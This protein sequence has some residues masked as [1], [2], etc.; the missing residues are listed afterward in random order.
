MPS[1]NSI[2]MSQ[3]IKI[4]YCLAGTF[5]S[6]GME[7]VVTD[8]ANWLAANGYD[9]TIVTT[10]QK[11]RGDF[12]PLDSSIR[13]IDLEILYSETNGFNPLKKYFAREKR[14]KLH[15][16]KLQSVVDSI[17]P[18]IIVS[19]FG[20][21][22]GIVPKIKTRAKK[23]A[24]IHFSKWY[25]MQL[26]RPG[27]WKWFDR[28]L[29][30]QDQSLLGYYNRFVALTEEDSKNW[31]RLG[32]MVVIP[33]FVKHIQPCGADLKNKKMVAV[34][35]LSYQKGY[36][37]MVKAWK[38]VTQKHPDWRME[39]FGSGELKEPIE[40]LIIAE[41]LQ[42]KVT[43]HRPVNDLDE[44]YVQASAL[45]L[46]SRYEGLPM[47][48]LEAMSYGVPPVAFACQCG[49]K[50]TITDG[51]NGL[52]VKEGDVE[53]LATAINRL[54]EDETLRKS[55]GENALQGAANFHIDRVM[56]KWVELFNE[57]LKDEPEELY[58]C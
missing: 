29:T 24:E 21:E 38:I 57:V 10:E 27:I 11:G 2:S 35:R 19:T 15:R 42:D 8:K 31:G 44:I 37:R 58:Y 41:N 9:I 20:N 46:S 45:I 51:E 43:I 3:P 13:R 33:N 16:Q 53:A 49:P 40:N 7:R 39:I 55:M 48:L 18:D 36:D 22:V 23:I 52:L 25:R 54:I 14:M 1:E 6:G 56:A 4:L 32:N 47:V 30:I 5:N 50:D 12:F 26:D 34:G 28:V 17:R